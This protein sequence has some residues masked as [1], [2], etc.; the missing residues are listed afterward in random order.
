VVIFSEKQSGRSVVA[1][2][3]VVVSSLTVADSYKLP[4]PTSQFY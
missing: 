2:R 4:G 1:A 3:S